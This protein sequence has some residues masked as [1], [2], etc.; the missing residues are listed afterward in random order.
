M[1]KLRFAACILA[2]SI[3]VSTTMA[4]NA[5]P[6][7]PPGAP[8]MTDAAPPPAPEAPAPAAALEEKITADFPKYD[9]DKSGELNKSEFSTW[10]SEAK[11]NAGGDAPDKKALSD[12]FLKADTD[13]SKTV[14]AK[15]LTSFLS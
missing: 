13:S 12:A 5:P 7:A 8:P 11:A 4:Q 14:S 10:I 2:L 9:K 15:E 3:P 1:K 6:S